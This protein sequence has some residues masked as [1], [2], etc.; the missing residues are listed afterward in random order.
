MFFCMSIRFVAHWNVPKAMAGYY[1]E[2][3]R[4]GRDGKQSYCRLYYS[5]EDRNTVGFLIKCESKRSKKVPNLE[6]VLQS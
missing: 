2:S 4:A 1:Q 5:H 3:G 6:S